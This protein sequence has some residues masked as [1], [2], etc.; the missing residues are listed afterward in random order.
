M[1]GR[2]GMGPSNMEAMTGRGMGTC[3]ASSNT[4]TG[5]SSGRRTGPRRSGGHGWRHCRFATSVP[6]SVC[7]GSGQQMSKEQEAEMLEEKAKVLQSE[8]DAISKRLN[9]TRTEN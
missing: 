9:E 8:L 1:P 2:N 7:Y 6:D 3:I 5:C 4:V